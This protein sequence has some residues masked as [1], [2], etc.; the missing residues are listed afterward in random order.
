MAAEGKKATL[1]I[2]AVS[3]AEVCA[4][5]QGRERDGGSPCNKKTDQSSKRTLLLFFQQM[6][7]DKDINAEHANR[8]ISHM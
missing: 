7:Q 8:L 6:E 2:K 3:Y 5:Y 4:H 1:K